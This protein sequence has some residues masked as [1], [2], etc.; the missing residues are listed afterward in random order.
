MRWA[1]SPVIVVGTALLARRADEAGRKRGYDG[2]LT[3]LLL[4]TG[5]YLSLLP[6]WPLVRPQTTLPVFALAAVLAVG[7][8]LEWGRYGRRG[9]GADSR[10]RETPAWLRAGVFVL[11]ATAVLISHPPKKS[12]TGEWEKML[13]Q[14]LSL[15]DRTDYVFDAKG[16]TVFRRRPYYYCI[17]TLT[18]ARLKRGLTAND[19][20]ERCIETR[21]CVMGGLVGRFPADVRE[22]MRENYLKAGSLYVAGRMIEEAQAGGGQAAAFDIV[23][24]AR[25]AVVTDGGAGR[26]TLDGTAYEGPRFLEAGRHEWVGEGAGGRTAAVWAQAVERGFVPEAVWR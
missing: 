8:W 3:F 16:E 23:I 17:E 4:A 10:R 20:I 15:T 6:V 14:V 5:A 21:T 7:L 26:G 25:Y 22:F 18:K 12:D 24:P 2:R 19:I 11:A 1:L 13:S 9:D